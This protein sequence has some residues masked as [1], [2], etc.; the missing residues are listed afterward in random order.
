MSAIRPDAEAQG[1]SACGLKGTTK[2]TT[3]VPIQLIQGASFDAETTRLLGLAYERACEGLAPDVP[4][5]EA[6]AKRIIVDAKR[7]ERDVER[8]IEYGLGRNDMLADAVRS[9][10]RRD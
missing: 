7:G 3:A 2:G 10:G 1:V 5:Q 6:I 4:V 8:L 9:G